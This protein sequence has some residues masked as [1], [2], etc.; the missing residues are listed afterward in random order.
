MVFRN[1]LLLAIILDMG[2]RYNEKFEIIVLLTFRIY[3]AVFLFFLKRIQKAEVK[4]M[5]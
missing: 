4:K 5:R 1:L 2:T 3:R